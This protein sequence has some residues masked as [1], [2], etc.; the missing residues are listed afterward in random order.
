MTSRQMVKDKLGEYEKRG[1]FSR[2]AGIRRLAGN[3]VGKA[4][5]NLETASAVFTH[6]S[7]PGLDRGSPSKP[8]HFYIIS[9]EIMLSLVR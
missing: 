4:R 8:K 9:V 2:N 3:F 5:H 1:F 7:S 6:K